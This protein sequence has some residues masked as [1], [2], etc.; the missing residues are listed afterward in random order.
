MNSPSSSASSAPATALVTNTASPLGQELARELARHGH[1]LVIVAPIEPELIG[2]ASRLQSE[3]GVNVRPVALD[4]RKEHSADELFALLTATGVNT[5]ILVN[6]DGDK[7]VTGRFL[8][9]M[10]ARGRGRILELGHASAT[11]GRETPDASRPLPAGAETPAD[12]LSETG[13]TLTLFR[14]DASADLAGG[15]PATLLG[16]ATPTPQEIAAAAYVA[17]IQGEPIL[18][19][20]RKT[21]DPAPAPVDAPPEPA[22]SAAE[23]APLVAM[24]AA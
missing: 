10:V 1:D 8:P 16:R 9:A 3:F 7:R 2:M 4:L 5:E 11:P 18:V 12:A 14:D 20:A 23:P 22:R 17:L 24:V 6:V 13:V 19:P 15:D 21:P